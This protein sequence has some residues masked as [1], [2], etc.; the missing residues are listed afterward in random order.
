MVEQKV[1]IAGTHWAAP[2]R[3]VPSADDH[4]NGLLQ[5][6]FLS[7]DGETRFRSCQ[8]HDLDI[9]AGPASP[10]RTE[11]L[12]AAITGDRYDA[13]VIQLVLE[14]RATGSTPAGPFVSE[15]GTITVLDFA[16]SF[17]I[18]DDEPR[19]V[20]HVAIPRARFL[21]H[22]EDVR[23]LH[24]RV[25]STARGCGALLGQLMRGLAEQMPHL[26]P[27]VAPI[28][29][30]TMV[31]LLLSALG[32][33]FTGDPARGSSRRAATA[34]QAQRL[35]ESQ[36]GSVDLT[37]EW[38]MTKLGISRSDLYSL[39]EGQGGVAR[40]IWRR[41]LEA[42]RLAL[43]DPGDARRIGEIAFAHGFSS[44]AHFARAFQAAFGTT[45]RATRQD[46]G[47]IET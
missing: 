41:R 14:G 9:V 24:G 29:G 2:P 33:E 11:R 26:P 1:G 18:V 34:Q 40:Y 27:L 43:L 44:Q 47:K 45:A 12:V 36:L 20:I 39:F 37:P 38:L 28:L 31:K 32:L 25:A 35:I 15:P 17:A 42:I 8:L 5:T 13:V 19:D 23:A 21:P 6:L 10:R 16:Q 46:R 7:A 22:V 4:L 30:E 3:A